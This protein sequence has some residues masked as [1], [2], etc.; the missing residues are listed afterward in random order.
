[1][2]SVDE[3]ADKNTKTTKLSWEFLSGDLISSGVG[4]LYITVTIIPPY[5]DF[6]K[7]PY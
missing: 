1:M 2:S 6:I 5:I 4:S 3:N 7:V